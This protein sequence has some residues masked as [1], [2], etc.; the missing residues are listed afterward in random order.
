[1]RIAA[2]ETPIGR[3]RSERAADDRGVYVVTNGIF[4]L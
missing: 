3:E 1:M 2:M 4:S